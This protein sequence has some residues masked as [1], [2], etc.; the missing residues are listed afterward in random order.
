MRVLGMKKI[1]NWYKSIPLRAQKVVW[2]I[3][4][5]I[6]VPV[7]F[8]V[9]NPEIGFIRGGLQALFNMIFAAV[10]LTLYKAL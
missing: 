1:K 6:L 3:T 9:M 10:I 7:F 8:L 4:V 5:A 2:D